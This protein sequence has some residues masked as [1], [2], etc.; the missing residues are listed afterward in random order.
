MSATFLTTNG[1]V[2]TQ[3]LPLR[4]VSD[5]LFGGETAIARLEE[6]VS[7]EVNISASVNGIRQCRYFKC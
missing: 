2:Y 7:V 6:K 4:V 3:L 1:T 5:G